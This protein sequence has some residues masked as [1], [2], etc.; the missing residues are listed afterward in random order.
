MENYLSTWAQTI[1]ILLGTVIFVVLCDVFQGVTKW[2]N[3]QSMDEHCKLRRK[4]IVFLSR[5]NLFWW[6]LLSNTFFFI[7]VFSLTVAWAVP[8][9]SNLHHFLH[10]CWVVWHVSLQF[11]WGYPHQPAKHLTLSGIYVY[12]YIY[13]GL[14][15][16]LSLSLSL[17]VPWK[18]H[19]EYGVSPVVSG[20]WATLQQQVRREGPH[21]L[22]VIFQHGRLLEHI[23][24]L[25][26]LRGWG[27][28]AI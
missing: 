3:K 17:R 18:F 1:T 27:M 14:F 2:F 11:W 19:L 9:V 6:V 13:V 24:E 12:L 21:Q 10:V 23:Q 25:L 7:G 15:L 8:F 20:I 22:A 5:T 26:R 16:S 4:M 28:V